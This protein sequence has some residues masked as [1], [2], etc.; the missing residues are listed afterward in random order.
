MK[1]DDKKIK[2][3]L[4]VLIIGVSAI[5]NTF[6]GWICARRKEAKFRKAA[7]DA[8]MSANAGRLRPDNPV[9]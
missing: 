7:E 3:I 5:A 9:A 2:P 6:L 1:D 8:E 4:G